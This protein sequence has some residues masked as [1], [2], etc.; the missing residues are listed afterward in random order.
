ME[1]WKL[2]RL[3]GWKL[4][5]APEV[6]PRPVASGDDE[7]ER[8][9]A[10]AKTLKDRKDRKDCQREEPQISQ[11]LSRLR[12]CYRTQD[13][14]NGETQMSQIDADFGVLAHADYQNIFKSQR[15]RR[16]QSVSRKLDNWWS[17]KRG[18]LPH[19]PAGRSSPC[20][21]GTSATCHNMTR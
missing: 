21:P 1:A 11:I 5:G 3:E 15:T 7:A 18:A 10:P 12:A 13:C 6:G 2:G 16:T 4:G 8:C 19:T 14:Q 17:G 20:T 9:A